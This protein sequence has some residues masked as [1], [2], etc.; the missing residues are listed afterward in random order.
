MADELITKYVFIDTSVF[1][2]RQFDF[3]SKAFTTLLELTQG[4]HAKLLTTAVT[5][6]ECRDHIR[7]EVEHA[8]SL[9]KRFAAEAWI[10]KRFPEYAVLFERADKAALTDRLIA[11]FEQ[12]LTVAGAESVDLAGAS[13]T[14]IVEQYFAQS[15]PFG[16]GAKKAEF[17][18]AIVLSAL[19]TW[20]ERSGDSVYVITRDNKMREAC[21]PDMELY[22]LSDVTDFL[23]LAN[24]HEDVAAD[25]ITRIF[26][27]NG[28]ALAALVA[29]EFEDLEFYVSDYDGDVEITSID[30][31]QVGEPE[32]VS[33][34]DRQATIEA[35]CEVVFSAEVSYE[36]PNTGIW[37][38]EDK[39]MLFMETVNKSVERTAWVTGEFIIEYESPAALADPDAAE[40]AILSLRRKRPIMINVDEWDDGE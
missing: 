30:R 10:L 25:R 5:V 29:E 18:D 3:Q 4:D 12:Y 34:E 9:R 14:D 11:E 2:Y 6:A 28:E 16:S 1:R 23:D 40:I 8:A 17:P 26:R 31:V 19:N 35:E 27:S 24:R 38:S 37:D 20:S 22:A 21:S 13:V 36:D 7:S 32:V 15:P 33:I 39:R